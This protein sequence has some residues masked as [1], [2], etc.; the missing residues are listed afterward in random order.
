MRPTPLGERMTDETAAPRG[1]LVDK[2]T[3]KV[4]E[5]VGNLAGKRDLAEEGE[6]QQA[7]ADA[8]PR[9]GCVQATARHGVRRPRRSPESPPRSRPR[10]STRRR[11]RSHW[12]RPSASTRSI[13]STEPI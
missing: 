6:L 1:G 3:G 4:K 12:T 8:A 13:V 2:L 11:P 5:A 10:P 7:R 9:A